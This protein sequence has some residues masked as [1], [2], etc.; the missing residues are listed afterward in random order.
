MNDAAVNRF[1]IVH[2]NAQMLA[3]VTAAR[4]LL[5]IVD[6]QA[7]RRPLH[8]VLT[9]GTM[10][11][12]VLAS[13]LRS[14]LVNAVDWSG[15]HLWW[16]D[17]RFLKDGDS[18][19]NEVQARDALLGALL[20]AGMLPE[21]NIHPIPAKDKWRSD[22]AQ[23][24]ETYATELAKYAAPGSTVVPDFDVV[25]LGMGP[26]GHVASLFPEYG[27]ILYDQGVT[28]SI[29]DSP[30][31]PPERVSL[32][33]PSINSA[34]EVWLIIAGAEKA[35]KA[36]EALAGGPIDDVPAAGVH[37]RHKTLFLMDTAAADAP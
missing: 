27:D 17:E 8:Y 29:T 5:R 26:D 3:D 6:T 7:V 25:M 23:A 34:R 30:K 10:G 24:A 9:G 36:A 33:F 31:P 37:G 4:W 11:I 15:V 1:V 21:D 20:K 12:A 22:P 28:V 32:T 35:E 14:P 2:S 18:D 13:A 19:R 16:G